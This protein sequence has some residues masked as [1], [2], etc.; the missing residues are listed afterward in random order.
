MKEKN[1][2]K[3]DDAL[4]NR[5]IGFTKNE[6][7]EEYSMIEDKLTLVKKKLNS[8]YYP[9]EL[10]AIEMLIEKYD[11][12]N[13]NVYDGLSLSEL[14]EEKNKLKKMLEEAQEKVKDVRKSKKKDEM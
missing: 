2:E 5:A 1:L 14:E 8:K 12:K 11:I 3:L 6:V 9:P 4:F 7:S 10:K 13:E